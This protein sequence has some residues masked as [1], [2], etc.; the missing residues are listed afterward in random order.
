MY[1]HYTIYIFIY[2]CIYIFFSIHLIYIY[3]DMFCHLN[4]VSLR[5]LQTFCLGFCHL[6]AYLFID[7]LQDL[8]FDISTFTKF[9]SNL[10]LMCSIKLSHGFEQYNLFL[11]RFLYI[12]ILLY[13]HK[14]IVDFPIENENTKPIEKLIGTFH[15]TEKCETNSIWPSFNSNF[16][17]KEQ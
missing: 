8:G 15:K 17:E 7:K 14:N 2:V 12:Q 4:V 5:F 1:Y 6:F 10:F 11:S 16:S 3:T 13:R 9:V